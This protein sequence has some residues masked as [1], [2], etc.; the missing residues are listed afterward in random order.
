MEDDVVY[1]ITKA[2]FENLDALTSMH[3]RGR[4]VNIDQAMEGMSVPLHPGA[5]RYLEE[6]G[7][8]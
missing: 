6:Q 4:D 1:E 8:L 2:V 5:E 3:E 7:A